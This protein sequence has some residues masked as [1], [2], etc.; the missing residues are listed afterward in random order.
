MSHTQLCSG[1]LP[2]LCSRITAR[3]LQDPKW[4]NLG[5]PQSS[6]SPKALWT[7]RVFKSLP[8]SCRPSILATPKTVSKRG[9]KKGKSWS[10]RAPEKEVPGNF[11]REPGQDLR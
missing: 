5:G 10:E 3:G 7:L 6:E 2:G 4:M 1:L 9:K 11:S 8:A